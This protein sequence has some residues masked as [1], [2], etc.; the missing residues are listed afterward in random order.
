MKPL[1]FI[2][3]ATLFISI[4]SYGQIKHDFICVDNYGTNRLIRINE[5]N[6]EKSWSVN[7]PKGSR[8]LQKL[9]DNELLVSHGNGAA[10]YDIETGEQ[11]KI[12]TDK[13]SRI[14][15]AQFYNGFYYLLSIKGAIYK[16][17]SQG[18]EVGN[19]AIDLDLD[20]RLLRFTTNGDFLISCKKPKAIITVDN[21]GTITKEIALPDKGYKALLIKNGNFLNTAGDEVKIVEVTA[22]GN[23]VNFVGGIAEHPSLNL[24]YCSGWDLLPNGNIVMCNW[25]GHNK[26]GTAPHL[27][28]FTRDNKAIW[29]WEDHE[30][31]RQVTNVLFLDK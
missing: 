25:L 11:L 20:V 26:H 22:D 15:S 21:S 2:L 31:A 14:Q 24:D 23:I 10:I 16:L 1:F 5:N 13:Y 6:P 4:N 27:I 8:D 3:F 29:K 18:K 12:I 17:N 30:V 28:E 9:S 19:I 7:V